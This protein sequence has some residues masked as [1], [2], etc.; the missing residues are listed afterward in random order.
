MATV[1]T[2]TVYNEPYGKDLTSARSYLHGLLTFASGSYIA[3]GL[4][5]NLSSAGILSTL[6]DQSGQNVLLATYTQPTT[7]LITGITVSGTTVTFLTKNPPV[8]GQYVTI[9]GFQ[10][11]LSKPING[12]TAKVATVSAGTSL[13]A[14]ITT[15][16]TTVTDSGQAVLVIGPDTMWIQTISGSGYVYGY[17]KTTGTIQIF[18]VDAAV[19]STQYPLIELSAGAL[20]A[21]VI[22]D[23]VE[24]ESEYVRD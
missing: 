10:N 22:A 14:T 11:A 23:V 4:L 17:N 12:I 1:L 3:G 24:F 13:T 7:S 21:G 9:A 19:V 6:Q 5:P 2:E 16:A 8:A 15:T 18:T 20:P